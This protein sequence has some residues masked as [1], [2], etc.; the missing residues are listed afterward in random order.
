MKPAVKQAFDPMG[1]GDIVELSTE[2]E[3]LKDQ[4]SDYDE[5][6]LAESK[7]KLLKQ[8]YD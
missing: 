1:E 7:A 3:T 4:I 6:W 5:K 2:D 8:I